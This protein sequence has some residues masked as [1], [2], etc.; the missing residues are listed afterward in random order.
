VFAYV[1]PTEDAAA[2]SAAVN[3][4]E[5]GHPTVGI[6]NVESTGWVVVL[7]LRPDIAKRQMEWIDGAGK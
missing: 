1:K 4:H 7:D 3:R 6:V 5:Y 2:R